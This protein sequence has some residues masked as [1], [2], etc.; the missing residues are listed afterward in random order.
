MSDD[1]V[2]AELRAAFAGNDDASAAWSETAPEIK[3]KCVAYVTAAR[4]ETDRRTRAR[5][6]ARLAAS[7]PIHEVGEGLPGVPDYL[8]HGFGGL[9]Q[10]P[11][12]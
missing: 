3:A 8:R 4:T 7:G 10:P 12:G 6:V 5:E 1:E 2:I 9:L 11:A